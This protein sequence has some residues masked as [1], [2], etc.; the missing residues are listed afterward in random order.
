MPNSHAVQVGEA[1]TN[2]SRVEMAGLGCRDLMRLE[3]GL[4]LH[5]NDMNPDTTV[6]EASLLWLI[7]K[8]R[9]EKG[10]FRGGEALKNPELKKKPRRMGFVVDKGA[11][12]RP[13]SKLEADGKQVGWVTS[14]T[15]SPVLKKAVGM[16]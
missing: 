12:M 16:A 11:P 10:D 9:R 6:I 15:F 3:A 14:G 8:A 2:D 1:L 4:C 13:G 7:P 5:G